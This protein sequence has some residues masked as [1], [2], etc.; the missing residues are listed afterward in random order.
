[1]ERDL[2]LVPRRPCV[3]F[4]L[5]TV[6]GVALADLLP[7]WLGLGLAGL[8]GLVLAR[9]RRW[10]QLGFARRPAVACLLLAAAGVGIVRARAVPRELPPQPP[11][12][13]VWVGGEVVG[14]VEGL[15]G[16][17][18]AFPLALEPGVT[19]RVEVRRPHVRGPL[20]AGARVRAL[21]RV[22]APG[23]PRDPGAFDRRTELARAG[24]SG[25]FLAAVVRVARTGRGPRALLAGQRTFLRRLLR[26]GVAAEREGFFR[27]IV[28]GERAEVPRALS[29]ALRRTGTLHLLSLSGL[30]VGVLAGL[31]L[32]LAR[33][34]GLDA[35][36]GAVVVAIALALYIGLAGPRLPTVR[37]ALAGV[38]FFAAPARGDPWNR[39]ALA[40]TVVLWWDPLALWDTTLHLSF[41][42]VAGLLL[43]GRP[44]ARA[45]AVP[46]VDPVLERPR[47]RGV[48][49]LGV[50]AAG[51]LTGFLASAPLLAGTLGQL[52]LTALLAG[53]PCLLLFSV[54][55]ALALAAAA[56]G[57]LVPPLGV[58]LLGA[59]DAAAALLLGVIE[60][61]ARIP[62]GFVELAPPDPAPL[63]LGLGALALAGVRREAG[64]GGRAPLALGGL[65][66]AA[67][68]LGPA[69]AAGPRVLVR[70]GGRTVLL[71]ADGDVVGA[72]AGG[73]PRGRP[74]WLVRAER[75][76]GR[77][78]RWPADAWLGPERRVARLELGGRRA[79][80]VADDRA[81]RASLAE[82]PPGHLAADVVVTRRALS[83][84]EARALLRA[85]G[86]PRAVLRDRPPPDAPPADWVAAGRGVDLRLGAGPASLVLR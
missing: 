3:P 16:G 53:A 6:A 86:A 5:A 63:V 36:Q 82:L 38:V 79:V 24:R 4:A 67:A 78:V 45:C 71:A 13:P 84:A 51:S 81:L 35:R 60:L 59:A 10:S 64:R 62:G 37:A 48:R 75:E 29:D 56:V 19:L 14:A 43:L 80:L 32:L 27:A 15:H 66:L 26:R 49:W 68:F 34:L 44:I 39:L 46:L 72:R 57:V 40:L 1:V 11:P 21:G 70:E 12:E 20:R 33:A 42:T 2:G 55:L 17:R 30:H 47:L 22:V 31:V 25:R 69:P 8:A 61:L 50:L 7:I 54:V 76:L 52:P 9:G 28:L 41:G 74:R 73:P 18:V 65:V 58:A 23:G 77:R 85:T 83:A